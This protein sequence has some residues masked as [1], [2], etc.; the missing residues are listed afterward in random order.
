MMILEWRHVIKMVNDICT[1]QEASRSAAMVIIM[2]AVAGSMEMAFLTIKPGKV[3]RLTSDADIGEH[4]ILWS[5]DIHLECFH[6]CR[7]CML[8]LKSW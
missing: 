6:L 2:R 1:C 8:V 7:E 4:L 5:H 3:D